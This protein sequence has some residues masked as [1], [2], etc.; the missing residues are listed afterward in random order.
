MRCYMGYLNWASPWASPPL[1]PNTIS[2]KTMYLVS[3]VMLSHRH[4]GLLAKAPPL[5][6]PAHHIS[7]EMTS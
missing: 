3:P 2:S 1:K 5:A 4:Q 6:F 7:P